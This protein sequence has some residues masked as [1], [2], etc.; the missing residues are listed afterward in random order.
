[1]TES[2]IAKTVGDAPTVQHHGDAG[3]DLTA[4]EDMYIEAGE[5]EKIGTNTSL[6]IPY[7][8]WGEIRSRSGLAFNHDVEAFSGTIDSGYRGEIMVKLRNLSDKGFI[9]KTGDRIAQ[10]VM[11]PVIEVAYVAADTLPDSGRGLNGFGSTGMN[12][13]AAERL[14]AQ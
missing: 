5:W 11:H 8:Y 12:S 2:I 1:M 10:L 4:S 6:A 9:V 7:G 3:A 14:A 13:E